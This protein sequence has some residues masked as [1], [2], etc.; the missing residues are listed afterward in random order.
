MGSEA[1]GLQENRHS[2]VAAG[3]FGRA[4]ASI[5]LGRQM[6]ALKEFFPNIRI[7]LRHLQN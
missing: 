6:D 3:N 7:I 2:T 5:L 1:T 4:K